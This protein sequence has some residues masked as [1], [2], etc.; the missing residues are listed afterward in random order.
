MRG[1]ETCH[2]S[3]ICRPGSYYDQ[4]CSTICND[5]HEGQPCCPH[6]LQEWTKEVCAVASSTSSVQLAP[7]PPRNVVMCHSFRCSW[8]RRLSDL[9]RLL[10]TCV[11]PWTDNLTTPQEHSHALH[12]RRSMLAC[13]FDCS[14]TCPQKMDLCRRHWATLGPRFDK[15]CL[16]VASVS[17]P[18]SSRLIFIFER[19]RQ[20]VTT[21]QLL[22][23]KYSDSNPYQ[24][25]ALLTLASF[26]EDSPYNCGLSAK[27]VRENI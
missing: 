27:L 18:C 19:R 16:S 17:S 15:G 24:S 6:T 1:S 12:T 7:T 25:A 2:N 26:I 5:N 14:A 4:V 9:S 10:H 21:S 3:G 11:I 13:C 22:V 8:H 23:A 20:A